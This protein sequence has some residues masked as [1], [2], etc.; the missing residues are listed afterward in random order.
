MSLILNQMQKH[1]CGLNFDQIE[2]LPQLSRKAVRQIQSKSIFFTVSNLQF[3]KC[4]RW[5]K[6]QPLINP[7]TKYPKQK[8]LIM[9]TK[10]FLS[11]AIMTM[12]ISQ[13]TNAQTAQVSKSLKNSA[14]ATLKGAPGQK[15]KGD[16]YFK[17][18]DLGVEVSIDV[19]QLK[20]GA[21][22]AI[23]IHENGKCDE[24]SFESAGGHFNPTKE[25]H[26]DPA[27][28]QHHLGDLGNIT[29]DKN[30]KAKK[31]LTISRAKF[32]DET[33]PVGKAV[34][35]HTNLDD[36][37]SQPSMSPNEKNLTHARNMVFQVFIIDQTIN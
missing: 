15:I 32:N 10:I 1:L 36:L 14:V 4:R 34:I 17:N 20:A 24:P 29:A 28:K 6:A 35:I 19:Q 2:F 16:V 9:K 23:H 21:V 5:E 26:A 31:V 13:I 27:A 33:S 7:T 37:K 11:F 22:H 3:C 8:E 30:G 25:P 12:L 18:S